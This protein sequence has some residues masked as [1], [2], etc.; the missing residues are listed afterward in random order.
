MIMGIIDYKNILTKSK[1][2][3]FVGNLE[4]KKIPKALD[5]NVA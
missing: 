5:K 1:H 2:L 4:V 3:K